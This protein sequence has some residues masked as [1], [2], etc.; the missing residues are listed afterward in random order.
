MNNSEFI[1][2]L[3]GEGLKKDK[4]PSPHVVAAK[5]LILIVIYF[6]L[7]TVF[8]GFRADILEKITQPLYLIELFSILLV[9]IASSYAA[10]YLA[11]PDDNQ[12]SWIRFLPFIPLIF[13]MGILVCGMCSP[14]SMTIMECIKMGQ[15]HCIIHIALYGILPGALMFYTIEKAAPIKCCW[16][17]SMAGLSVASFG[18]ITLRLTSNGDDPALLFVWNF[19]PIFVIVMIGM[20]LGKIFL[21]HIW[22]S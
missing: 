10:S 12:V 16:A 4:F 20:M 22:K 21:S 2:K 1:N 8:S 14:S 17:G 9:A 15:Y 11:L 18:Y 6:T 13:L 3:A 5:W 7:L 19:L